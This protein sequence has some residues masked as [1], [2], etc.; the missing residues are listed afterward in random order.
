MTEKEGAARG[1]S[2]GG[3]GVG[4]QRQQQL[5]VGGEGEHCTGGPA[6]GHIWLGVLRWK[7]KC[8]SR[9]REGLELYPKD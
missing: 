3:W 9:N 5:L 8:H 7:D 4:E 1:W 2:G 6:G